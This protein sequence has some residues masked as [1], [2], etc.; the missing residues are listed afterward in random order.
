[1]CLLERTASG[2]VPPGCRAIQVMLTARSTT[3]TND[4][5]ADELSLVLTSLN[6]SPLSLSIAVTEGT[7]A[8][9]RFMSQTNRVYL[10]QRTENLASWADA[11]GEIAGTGDELT[12]TDAIPPPGQAFY[13]VRS[14]KP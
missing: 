2:R 8:R 4:A 7:G 9:I 3:Q 11:G 13:L 10:L 1:M 12:L 14:R 6:D 5:S